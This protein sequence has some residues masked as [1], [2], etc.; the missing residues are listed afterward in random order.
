MHCQSP[1]QPHFT[2]RQR[3]KVD[4]VESQFGLCFLNEARIVEIPY[5]KC[6]K[7]FVPGR[8]YGPRRSSAKSRSFTSRA[9]VRIRVGSPAILKDVGLV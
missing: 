1:N 5:D 3:R 4:V 6:S 2:E 8:I 9:T 7:A